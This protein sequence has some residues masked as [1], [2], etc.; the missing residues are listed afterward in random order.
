MVRDSGLCQCP[1]CLG[2]GKRVTL[3]HEV[4]HI[5]SKARAAAMGWTQERTD[6]LANL[7]AVNRECH[8]RITM[9]EQGRTPASQP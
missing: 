6:S 8:K 3:A 4:D 7:R 9:I 5:V 1:D 2:G